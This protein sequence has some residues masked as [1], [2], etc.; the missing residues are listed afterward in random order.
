MT[1]LYPNLC[2]KR[3]IIKGQFS[4]RNY[5]YCKI[6]WVKKFVGHDYDRIISKLCVIRGVL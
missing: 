2:Y 4:Q 1:V 6:P 5:N 3:C